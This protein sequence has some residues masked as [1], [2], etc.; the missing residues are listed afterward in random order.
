MIAS[1]EDALALYTTGEGSYRAYADPDN[2]AGTGMFGGW[3]AA[4]L[5]KSVLCDPGAQGEAASLNVNYIRRIPPKSELTV[6]CVKLGGSQSVATWRADIF[7][8]SREAPSAT[9]TIVLANKRDSDGFTERAPPEAPDP[10]S[11]PMIHPPASFGQRVDMRAWTIPFGQESSR[12]ANWIRERS[13]HPVDH[14]LLAYLS[15]AYPPRIFMRSAGPRP[16]S[17]LTLSA[18]FYASADELAGIGEDFILSEA[19]GTRAGASI[20]GSQ[21]NMWSRSGA[22]LATSE[23][24]CW[25]K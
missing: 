18:Y 5:L 15:D 17:T 21:L 6:K 16:S 14:V 4:L 10:N 11:L 23:Q 2:E 25:F 1:L 19:V 20:I 22:L 13:G 12:S 8:E 7:V 9:A 3:T 24:L